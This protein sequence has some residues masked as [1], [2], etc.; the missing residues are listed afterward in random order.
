M[1]IAILAALAMAPLILHGPVRSRVSRAQSAGEP[2]SVRS[3]NDTA[4]RTFLS[5][6][7]QGA[8]DYP[9]GANYVCRGVGTGPSAEVLIYENDK[10]SCGS[11][12][13]TLLV[14]VP[15]SDLGYLVVGDIRTVWAPIRVLKSKTHGL[16]DLVGHVAGGGIIPGH[17]AKLS[18]DGKS[19]PPGGSSGTRIPSG[20]PLGTM[21][22]SRAMAAHPHVM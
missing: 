15:N 5:G 22:I 20:S 7:A 18:Y 10:D 14:L 1:K 6:M 2:V 13:C 8:R 17:N 3:C 21:V 19:Y 9:G 11:G 12:G 16:F 4:I